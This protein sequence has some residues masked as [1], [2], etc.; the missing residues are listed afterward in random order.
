MCIC[1][2]LKDFIIRV[3]YI[4]IT[5]YK[6]LRI[7]IIIYIYYYVYI[8]IYLTMCINI[9]IYYI[10]LTYVCVDLLVFSFSLSLSFSGMYIYI[11]HSIKTHVLYKQIYLICPVPIHPLPLWLRRCRSVDSNSRSRTSPSG[12]WE[13]NYN[14]D[15]SLLLR[16]LFCETGLMWVNHCRKP[17]P[18]HYH[19]IGGISWICTIPSHGWFMALFYPPYPIINHD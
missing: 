6:L 14:I 12:A 7:N 18:N 4:Y 17:S 9:Y 19:F 1:F 15:K 5:M 11:Y 8:Y 2:L 16:W 13:Q 10:V 3:I